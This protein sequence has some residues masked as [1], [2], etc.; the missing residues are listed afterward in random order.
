M[1]PLATRVLWRRAQDFLAR[2]K[3]TLIV[4]A[5]TNYGQLTLHAVKLLL[6]SHHYLRLAKASK[7]GRAGVAL[8]ILGVKPRGAARW[9]QSLTRSAVRE[10]REAEPDI[11]AVELE[12]EKPG[13]IDWMAKRLPSHIGILTAV[14]SEHLD[15]FGDKVALVHEYASLIATIPRDGHVIL[16]ADEPDIAALNQRTKAHAHMVSPTQPADVHISRLH[17]LNPSGLAV[18]IVIQNDKYELT[19][20]HIVSNAQMPAILAAIAAAA[21]IDKRSLGNLK[22]LSQLRPSVGEFEVRQ[23]PAGSITIDISQARTPEVAIAALE[24]LGEISARR[25][26]AII[27]G[28]TSLGRESAAWQKQIGQATSVCDM[29]L[30]VG[31]EMRFAVAQARQT[32]PNLDIH[33][34][35]SSAAALTWLGKYLKKGDWLLLAA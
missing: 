20:P 8:S 30:V 22:H 11:I 21:L 13:D 4:V 18:E 6:D 24:S 34:F 16:N 15:V 12:A 14:G 7:A 9:F 1:Q 5:G 2:H 26:I 3:P 23:H 25:R 32:K 33:H 31:E 17:R 10:L 27:S 19:L 29:L 35:S 28:F